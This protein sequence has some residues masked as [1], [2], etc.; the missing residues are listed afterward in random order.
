MLGIVTHIF[1]H[2]SQ[3]IAQMRYHG[4]RCIWDVMRKLTQENCRI[5]V[6]VKPQLHEGALPSICAYS[7]QR[8]S[9]PPQVGQ[10][11]A[12]VHPLRLRA[13]VVMRS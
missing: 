5:A 6:G 11:S 9:L 3:G 1:A 7:G 4:R 8:I 10:H 13:L 12:L 2:V